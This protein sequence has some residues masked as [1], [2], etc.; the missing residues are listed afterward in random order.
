M[1]KKGMLVS[2]AIAP[3]PEQPIISAGMQ[4]EADNQKVQSVLNNAKSQ[5]KFI[6]KDTLA[7]ANRTKQLGGSYLEAWPKGETGYVGAVRPK[8]LP[9]DKHGLE[10]TRVDEVGI[11]DIAGDTLHHDNYAHEV[12][13]KLGQSIVNNPEQL[14]KLKAIARDYSFS[15][16]RGMSESDSIRNAVDSAMRGHVVEQ[17][18]ADKVA[19]MMYTPDQSK[20]LEGLKSYMVTGKK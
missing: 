5:Y 1:S 20:L 16:D 19:A 6:P 17:W 7:V 4:Q 14:N 11:K 12:R 10:V 8:E 9:I 15:K 2:E 3:I 18:P 13:T